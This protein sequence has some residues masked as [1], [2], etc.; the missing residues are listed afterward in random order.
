MWSIASSK[1]FSFHK[2]FSSHPFSFGAFKVTKVVCQGFVSWFG[3]FFF[4]GSTFYS[5][6]RELI[7]RLPYKLHRDIRLIVFY[8]QQTFIN[9]AKAFV[10]ISLWTH[11]VKF[12]YF[13]LV[14]NGQNRMSNL[15]PENDL[16]IEKRWVFNEITPS[17]K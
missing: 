1:I 3:D 12:F 5:I 4:V 15:Q 9:W 13:S 16:K 6:I 8:T 2:I 7:Y 17:K 11:I 10:P 14:K